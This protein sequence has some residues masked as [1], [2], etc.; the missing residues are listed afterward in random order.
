MAICP[1]CRAH[2]PD[3]VTRCPDDGDT[4]LPSASFARADAELE[5]GTM[6]GE[7]CIEEKIGSGGF[8][9]VY[10]A[11]HPLIGKLA[12]VKVLGASFSSNPEMVS[13]FVSEARAANTIQDPHII[14]IFSFGVLDDG[15]QYLV[16]E[17]LAGIGFEQLIEQHA[18]LSPAL[19]LQIMDGVARALDA[20]HE[21]DIVHRDLK[22]DNVFLV[23]DEDGA[24]VVKLLDFGVAKLL[25]DH[26][27]SHKTGTGAPVGTPHY[28]SPEQCMGIEVDHGADIYA[29]GVVCFEALTG[30]RP[31]TGDSYLKL[32]SQHVSAPVPLASERNP[33]LGSHFDGILGDLMAKEPEDR[34]PSLGRAME[35]LSEAARQQGCPVDAPPPLPAEV[36]RT[37]KRSRTPDRSAATGRSG[38]STEATRKLG[39]AQTL[40]ESIT[41]GKG[42]D[43]S[44]RGAA[45]SLWLLAG[46]AILAVAAYV[47]SGMVAGPGADAASSPT[48]GPGPD[49]A[50]VDAGGASPPPSA[51]EVA[52]LRPPAEAGSAGSSE[53][54]RIK[55]RVESSAPGA[56]VFLD[57]KKLGVAPGPFSVD[58][59]AGVQVLIVQAPGY[60]PAKQNV[61]LDDDRSLSIQ[62][63]RR[64]LKPRPS[65]P[66]PVP[67]DLEL[68]TYP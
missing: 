17:L 11:K 26:V 25:G 46:A 23:V 42:S 31:F 38:P 7:Y 68:P 39:A 58:R 54:D 1:T 43:G 51:S 18:P 41:D 22:P 19:V 32:L 61:E 13:R 21:A 3:D 59:S 67:T 55:L 63:E 6:V 65:N 37:V 8:G 45:S 52:E 49:P 24:P 14:D 28:M 20:A 27:V 50:F 66:A 4:L 53:P 30:T 44:G 60:E 48:A 40:G 57:G 64:V 29:F 36:L 2:F 33:E 16:M 34:P 56:I 47:A 35:R 15:R 9:A 5:A 62:L 12:A 10:R